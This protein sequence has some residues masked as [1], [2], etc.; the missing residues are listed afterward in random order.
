[1]GSRSRGLIMV[2]T[3]YPH[4]SLWTCK[5]CFG[6]ERRDFFKPYCAVCQTFRACPHNGGILV[7]TDNGNMWVWPDRTAFH[8]PLREESQQ[9]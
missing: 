4:Q 8:Q 7:K 1:M 3:D 6:V 9:V 5:T 2:N